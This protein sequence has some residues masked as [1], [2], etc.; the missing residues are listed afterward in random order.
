MKNRS[1]ELKAEPIDVTEQ[2]NIVHE[3]KLAAV[4]QSSQT[5]LLFCLLFAAI[6]CIFFSCFCFS[7]L[8]PW[9]ISHQSVFR[10]LV[11]L[12][13]FNIFYAFSCFSFTVLGFSLTVGDELSI[14][15]S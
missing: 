15:S 9:E 8:N 13:L 12:H 7:L 11:P 14:A 10:D 3:L 6:G 1:R 5:R 2:E 4:R